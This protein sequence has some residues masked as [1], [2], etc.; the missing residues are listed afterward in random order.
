MCIDY[1]CQLTVVSM[2]PN[3]AA[4]SCGEKSRRT[5]GVG[6]VGWRVRLERVGHR[7]RRG[8]RGVKGGAGRTRGRDNASELA[9]MEQNEGGGLSL[10]LTAGEGAEETWLVCQRREEEIGEEDNA[11]NAELKNLKNDV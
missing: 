11:A 3:G 7:R 6:R 9:E 4:G 1:E 8:L 2:E 10:S 5:R